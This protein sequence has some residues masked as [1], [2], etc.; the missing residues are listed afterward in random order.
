GLHGKLNIES[1]LMETYGFSPAASLRCGPRRM[2][3]SLELWCWNGAA[4]GPKGDRRPFSLHLETLPHKAVQQSNQH[5]SFIGGILSFN[6][7]GLPW[8]LNWPL[9][10]GHARVNPIYVTN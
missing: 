2:N 7:S 6:W 1:L 8:R 5:L 10:C 4:D 9:D 3:F